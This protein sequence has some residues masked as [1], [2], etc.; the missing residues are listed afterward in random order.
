MH[1]FGQSGDLDAR[2]VKLNFH[3]FLCMARLIANFETGFA[4]IHSFKSRPCINYYSL[5][6]CSNLEN[7][8]HSEKERTR[9]SGHMNL[10][11]NFLK[12]RP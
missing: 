11:D 3:R 12:G 6:V 10:S 5:Y 2:H 9:N 4:Q 1:V 8:H 7:S